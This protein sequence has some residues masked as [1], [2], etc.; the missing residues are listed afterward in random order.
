[1]FDGIHGMFLEGDLGPLDGFGTQGAKSV[2]CQAYFDIRAMQPSRFTIRFQGSYH[3]SKDIGAQVND[4]D[5]LTV[6][7][8]S[9][10]GMLYR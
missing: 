7:K 4:G 10:R 5:A 2:R 3:Q 9:P 6:F 8:E 1:M